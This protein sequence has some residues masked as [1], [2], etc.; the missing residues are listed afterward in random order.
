[1]KRIFTLMFAAAALLS[2]C[3]KADLDGIREEQANQSE[4]LAALEEWQKQVNGEIGTLQTIVKALEGN[5]YVTSVAPLADGSGYTIE[6]VKSGSVVIK[7]GEKGGAPAVSVGQDSDGKY[8]WTLDGEWLT[9]DSGNKVPA[10]GAQG[11]PGA[12]AVAPQVRINTQGEW[13]ISIDGGTDWSPT[14]VK[15]T[16]DSMFSSLDT[17]ADD[18]VELTLADGVTK[19]KLPRYKAFRIGA[20]GN[21]ATIEINKYLSVYLTMPDGIKK[22]DYTAI[23]AQLTT[24]DGAES[25]IRLCAASSRW[26]VSVQE[27]TF[28]AEGVYKN[29]ARVFVEASDAIYGELLMLEVTLVC[30][31]GSKLTAARPLVCKAM[32]KVSVKAGSFMMGSDPAADPDCLN[33]ETPQHK[34]TLTQDFDMGK[35]LVTTSHYADFLN[36]AGIVGTGG[37]EEVYGE[38]DGFGNQKLCLTNSVWTIRWNVADAKW[39]AVSGHE[40]YPMDDVTWFGAKAFADWVGGALPTEAQ[41]EYACRA[42]TTTRYSFGDDASKLGD[43][44]WY[45]DNKNFNGTHPV[46][47]KLPN[48]WGLYDMHGNVYEWCS[49]WYAWYGADDATDPVGPDT[50]T[51]RVLRGGSYF[52]GA[53]YCRSASRNYNGPAHVDSLCG[54]RVVF[55]P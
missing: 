37:N 24:R 12:A 42:G 2:G 50:G 29:D 3:M 51:S 22:G 9:D 43:Y 35:Y 11:E 10:T 23:M 31:D 26:R 46:G 39:Q 8:Y 38:V 19:I 54:F 18:Y 25:D 40:T 32:D 52:S 16:G 17:S 15:A 5:D 48:P 28:D 55:V 36:S 13:E 44:A 33:H 53:G 21:N 47:M 34:V 27:P 14:G 20:D 41:W 7:H 4:R 49:D 1:M 30:S 6:F 45:R